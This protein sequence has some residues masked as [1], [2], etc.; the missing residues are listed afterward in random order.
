MADIGVVVIGRNEGERLKRCLE[1][2]R[3]QVGQVV[4]VD[5]G[6]SDA[7]VEYARSRQVQVVCLDMTIPFSAGRARNEGFACLQEGRGGTGL[8]FVQFVDGDCELEPGW[9][10][11]ARDFLLA[12]E[13]FAV[14][15]GRR[16]EKFPEASVYNLLCDIEWNTPIGEARACGGDFL[17]RAEAFGQVGGFNPAVVAGEEPELCYRLRQRSWRVMR[18]AEAMTRHDAAITTFGQWWRRSLRTGHAFAQG[19]ALHGRAGRERYY[20]R[21]SLQSWF[22]ALLLPL[23]V[24]VLAVMGGGKILLLLPLVYG[25]QMARIFCRSH[26]RLG[27]APAAPYAFF[28]LLGKWPQFMG[29]LLFVKR[30]LRGRDFAIIEYS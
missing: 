7:S 14:A 18:L 6:S 11:A 26:K 21:E 30:R 16:K 22:W 29:Q 8:R 20:R 4:Y 9:L 10:K 28:T 25:L 23:L 2:V 1:S 15:A 24:V 12:H 5:S 13:D 27:R 19:Y 3:D 17:A